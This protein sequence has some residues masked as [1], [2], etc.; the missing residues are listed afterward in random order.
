M[1]MARA[2]D[3]HPLQVDFDRARLKRKLFG[4][5]HPGATILVDRFEL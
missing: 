1:S 5:E 2:I 4:P 3:G